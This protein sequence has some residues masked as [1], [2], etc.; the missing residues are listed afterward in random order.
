MNESLVPSSHDRRDLSFTDNENETFNSL[1]MLFNEDQKNSTMSSSISLLKSE[2][3]SI[4]CIST[5]NKQKSSSVISNRPNGEVAFDFN[6]W[7]LLFMDSDEEQTV[8]SYYQL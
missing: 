2:L 5:S 7:L 6:P 1:S 3:P 4:N 8:R